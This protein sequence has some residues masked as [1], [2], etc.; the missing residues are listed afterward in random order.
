MAERNVF[1]GGMHWGRGGMIL[2]LFCSACDG[3]IFLSSIAAALVNCVC[4]IGVELHR[5][6][7]TIG[8][9]EL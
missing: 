3:V 5:A 8:I 2:G 1:R 7:Y 6:L 4:E 9:S